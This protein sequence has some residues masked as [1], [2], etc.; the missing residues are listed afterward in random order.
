M[1]NHFHLV[2]ETPEPTL[3]LGMRDIG[4]RYAQHFNKR[5]LTGG[6]HVFQA[7]F[8]SRLTTSDEQFAQLLRYVA[9][10]PVRANLCGSPEDWRWSAHI[11][12][13]TNAPHPL[14]AIPRVTALLTSFGGEPETRYSRLF[15]SDGPLRHIEADLSPWELRPTLSEIFRTDEQSR[16]IR[17]ARR[18]GYRLA[19]IAAHTGLSEATVSRRA[20]R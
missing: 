20:K 2:I 14:V 19:E 18:Y 9:R 4:S 12:L 11:A 16:A 8:G 6:G 7:R 10:N 1:H 17:R 13:V 15:D 5:H 3:G